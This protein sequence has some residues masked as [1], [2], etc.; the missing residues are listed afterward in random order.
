M[1]IL[2]ILQQHITLHSSR[3]GGYLANTALNIHYYNGGE[4]EAGGHD[5]T[6]CASNRTSYRND[7]A[8]TTQMSAHTQNRALA[9]NSALQIMEIN[10]RFGLKVCMQGTVFQLED[11]SKQICA[12]QM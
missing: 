11:V 6:G 1:L 12:Y 9:K 10:S 8:K 7:A 5:T 2:L 4:V 3:S